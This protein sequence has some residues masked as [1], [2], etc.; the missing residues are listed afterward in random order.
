MQNLKDGSLCR[1]HNLI[2]EAARISL[3]WVP[4]N[5]L[6]EL[7]EKHF[8]FPFIFIGKWTMAFLTG[9]SWNVLKSW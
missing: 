5:G 2:S 3:F 4:H 7:P 6:S 1:R 9:Q 8:K